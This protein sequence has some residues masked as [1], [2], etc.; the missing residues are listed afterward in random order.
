MGMFFCYF[1]YKVTDREDRTKAHFRELEEETVRA[2][3]IPLLQVVCMIVRF[4]HAKNLSEKDKAALSKHKRR[5]GSFDILYSNNGQ[6]HAAEA[7]CTF[8]VRPGGK[9]CTVELMTLTHALLDTLLRAENKKETRVANPVDQ[10]ICL[11]TLRPDSQWARANTF[12][13]Y[14][15]QMQFGGYSVMTQIARLIQHGE[16][17][18]LPVDPLDSTLD[19][20]GPPGNDSVAIAGARTISPT[21]ESHD[22]EPDIDSDSE[23]DSNAET[24]TDSDSDVELD[25]ESEP[26]DDTQAP[27]P[28][29]TSLGPIHPLCEQPDGQQSLLL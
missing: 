28:E 22:S 26:L 24:D 10:S 13:R 21:P 29:E 18:Y 6:K 14:C 1:Y 8:M 12:T 5:Y 7:L 2:Y 23:N 15:A 11:S 19:T 3:R 20:E 25:F 4:C 9:T 27:L 17:G 16:I